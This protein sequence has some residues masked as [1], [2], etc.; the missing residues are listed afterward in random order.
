MAFLGLHFLQNFRR[1]L[2]GK[3]GQQV[4]G[5]VGIHFF[6]D[7]GGASVVQRLNNGFLHSRLYLFECLGSDF[8]VQSLKHGLALIGREALDDVC[9][10]RRM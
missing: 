8:L 5:G 4:G 3:I 7:F 2:F 10:I 6:D 9:D 1:A